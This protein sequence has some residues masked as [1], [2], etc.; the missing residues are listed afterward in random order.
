MRNLFRMGVVGFLAG[1][2]ANSFAQE[3]VSE[4]PFV[5]RALTKPGEFTLG[6]EG[7]NCDAAGNIFAVNF[8]KEQTIGK[9]TPLGKAE[10]FLTLPGKSTGNGIV[11]TPEGIMYVADY[12]EH[13][14]WRIDPKTKEFEVFAHEPKMSQPNDLAIAPD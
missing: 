4:K 7:P 14:I 2:I 13:K 1:Y 9:V 10:V 11:F 12:V 3:S 5:A 8:A 6:I